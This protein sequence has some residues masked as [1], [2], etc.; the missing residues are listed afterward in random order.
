MPGARTMVATA[1]LCLGAL[2]VYVPWRAAD[3]YRN[4]RGIRPDFVKLKNEPAYRDGLILVSGARHPAWASAALANELR[5]G[6]SAAPVFAWDRDAATR[7][8]VLNA[9]PTRPVWLVR[10]PSE[11]G[12]F[13]MLRGPI[14]PAERAGLD[15][16]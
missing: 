11:S 10:G 9:F 15:Q 3:K 6:A 1:V 13:E 7:Q 8:A 12:G 16:P 2:V 4:Y 14:S 5:I